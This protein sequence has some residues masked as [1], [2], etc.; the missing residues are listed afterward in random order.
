MTVLDMKIIVL[1]DA[2]ALHGFGSEHGLSYLI[3]ADR[4]NILFDTGASDV[5]MKNAGILGID[6]T[7]IDAIVLSHGHFDHG[8]G[9][10]FIDG[11][12]LIC[13]PGSFVRRY[14]E[15]GV[16]YIGLALTRADIEK[17]FELRTSAGPVQISEHLVFLGEIPRLNNFEAR[18]TRYFLEGGEGDEIRDDS[19]LACITKSGLVVVSGCAHAGIC[20]MVEHAR[21]VTGMDHVEGVIGGFHLR[22]I[23]PQTRK[24]IQYF[25]RI[26]VRRVYPSHCTAEPALSRF[27]DEF[28]LNEVYAG[29]TIV[30][31]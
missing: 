27:H 18:G 12:P 29:G 10:Q 23:N 21:K 16:G 19:G 22:E 28:G 7:V 6:L 17:K 13:H 31:N 2:K 20:N 3:E 30:F 11:K 4:K 9:L 25:K 14:H 5:F 8:D 15:Q 24:T 26:G 1:S